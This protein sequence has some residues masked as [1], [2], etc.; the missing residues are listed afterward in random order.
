[1][2]YFADIK[3]VE[4][5]GRE[6]KNPLA[7]KFYDPKRIVDG[8]SMEEQL[9]FALSYWHTMDNGNND[10]FG[11]AATDKSFGGKSEIEIYEQKVYA[12]FEIMEK[13]S[14]RYFCFHDVDIAPYGNSL[15]EYQANLD[16]IVDLIEKEMERTGIK[17]LWNT[18]NLFNAPRYEHGAM[19]S[20]YADVYCFAAC[21]V[22]KALDIAIRLKSQGFVF[23][24]G[25]EGYSTLLN[26][27]MG[28][29]EKNMANFFK[30]AIKYARD[31]GFEGDF[32]IEPKPKEPTKH[33]Y[34]FDAATTIS[35]LRKYDLIND[36]K[37][38]LEANHATLAAHTFQH[39]LRVARE[40]GVLGSLDVNQGDPLLGWDTDQFPT[41]IKDATLMMYEVKK[42]G[43]LH[44]GGLNFDAKTRRGSF[45]LEDIFK[46][47]IA[48]MDTI[49]FGLLAAQNLIEDGRIDGFIA[50]RYESYTHGIGKKISDGETTLEECAKYGKE[51]GEPVIDSGNQEYLESVVNQV[52]LNTK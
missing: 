38:N 43:G 25:R 46:A 28:L 18:T 34:D 45:K 2:A 29:E 15:E 23:W 48:G 32:Y 17:V 49:A 13:L 50:K 22:K 51:L 21:Q 11:S 4:F 14:I 41:D 30:M 19:S 36:I 9:P 24:G 31:N 1:M 37:L 20:P 12:A 47:Y 39:E 7:F 33:Q 27:D 5:E 6:S 40:N 52:M 35:F 26:T 3:K 8:K 42:N 44:K 10:M 16:H